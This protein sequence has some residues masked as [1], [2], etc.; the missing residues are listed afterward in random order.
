MRSGIVP[1]LVEGY[2]PPPQWA[3]EF[4]PVHN[5]Q[6]IFY[7]DF[8]EA[9]D[10][11]NDGGSA[12]TNQE[13]DVTQD[14]DNGKKRKRDEDRYE[15]CPLKTRVIERERLGE[16]PERSQCFGCV[17]FG[18]RDT[19]VPFEQLNILI[20]MARQSMGRT[21]MVVLAEHMATYYEE[22]V[23]H[24]INRSLL[25]GERMLGPWPASQILEH[26]RHHNQDPQVQQVVLLAE[27][28]EMRALLLDCCFERSVKTK[29]IR[30]NK[31]NIDCYDKIVKLQ[32]LTH[33]QD[34]AKMAFYSANARI[35]DE[36]LSELIST[37]TKRVHKQWGLK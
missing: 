14:T 22:E 37:Q 26:L 36:M 32:L 7:N 16:P 31:H 24:R 8:H 13:V 18:E 12:N 29:A 4:N 30:P 5:N 35:K 15:P 17:Y 19:S 6:V 28:Q 21:D 1:T 10:I 34:A 23:R 11:G 3:V 2:V 20:D 33:K 9:N 27:M 25:P